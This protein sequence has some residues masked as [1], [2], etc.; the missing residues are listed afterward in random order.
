MKSAKPV[1]ANVNGI[2]P[3]LMKLNKVKSLVVNDN[4]TLPKKAISLSTPKSP[5]AKK[6]MVVIPNRE[7]STDLT[8]LTIKGSVAE[9][10]ML[11]KVCQRKV[12]KL[13]TAKLN[14]AL[15]DRTKLN[16]FKEL[17]MKLNVAL[18]NRLRKV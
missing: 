1:A 3:N 6:V 11:R 17:A 15:P 18:P 12:A 13:F 10:N 14:M 7:N 2:V 8:M 4:S 5:F 16:K 9:P